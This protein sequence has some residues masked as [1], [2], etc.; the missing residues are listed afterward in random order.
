[1]IFVIQNANEE[2]STNVSKVN[3]TYRAS[4]GW[5][6]FVFFLWDISGDRGDRE[7]GRSGDQEI[8]KRKRIAAPMAIARTYLALGLDD[9]K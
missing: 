3:D 1:M 8:A 5:F 9:T 4:V 6:F 2:N 7:I